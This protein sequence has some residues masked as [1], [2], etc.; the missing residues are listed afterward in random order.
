M[1]AALRRLVVDR[2]QGRCEYCLTPAALATL[3]HQIDHI[4]AQKH[5]GPT[6][7]DNLC[8]ACAECNAPKGPNISGIDPHSGRMVRL[9][10]PRRD[11][12]REH[13][14]WDG[15]SLRGRTSIGRATIEVL[16]INLPERVETRRL[17][18]R[19]GLFATET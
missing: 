7:A 10:H 12:W 17:L 13:F 14:E 9:F 1:D 16:N 8:Y 11:V 4:R 19:A 5:R 6:S 18:I 2:A 15:P 3:P